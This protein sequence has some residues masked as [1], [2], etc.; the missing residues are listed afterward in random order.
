MDDSNFQREVLDRLIVLETLIKQQDYKSLN[1][2]VETQHDYLLKDEQKLKNHEERPKK[3][4]D[5]NKWLTIYKN[6]IAVNANPRNLSARDMVYA[7]NT[8]M[9]VQ[10]NDIIYLEVNGTSGDI[11]RSGI[12]YTNLTIEVVQ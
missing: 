2:K 7:T 11:I 9:Q 1:Q 12:E 3:I 4:E 8:L 6:G 10:E 5:N